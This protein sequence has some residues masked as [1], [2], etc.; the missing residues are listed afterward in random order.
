M[1][2]ITKAEW[3]QVHQKACDIANATMMEDDV[4]AGSHQVAMH[5][6]LDDLERAHG[7]QPATLA[8]RADYTDDIAE[9][10]ALFDRALIMARQRGETDEEMEILDSL[11]MLDEETT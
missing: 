8:T 11:R 5:Q 4:L 3:D 10:R 1:K 2:S 7:V 9:Q 6:M